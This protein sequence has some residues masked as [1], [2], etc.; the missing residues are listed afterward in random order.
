MRGGSKTD[1]PMS[2]LS[3][4]IS[5]R[6]LQL[7]CAIK[8]KVLVLLSLPTELADGLRLKGVS[9]SWRLAPKIGS[10]VLTPKLTVKIC[11]LE[12]D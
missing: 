8:A 3:L 6:R 5:A 9:L 1:I 12:L 10:S 4:A 11:Q 2:W 7:P